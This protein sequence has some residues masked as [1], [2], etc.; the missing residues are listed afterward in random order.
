MFVIDRFQ[1]VMGFLSTFTSFK[2]TK[3]AGRLTFTSINP[4]CSVLKPP[5]LFNSS[6]I[7]AVMW[8]FKAIKHKTMDYLYWMHIMGYWDQ[9][10]PVDSMRL[11]VF[12]VSPN[13]KI[14]YIWYIY[15]IVS[16]TFKNLPNN[17]GASWFQRFLRLL[18]LYVRR[19]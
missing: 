4:R 1:H 8:I 7:S 15:P 3:N 18:V 16:K 9:P 2:W 14:L 12:T 11:A 19:I 5:M 13:C 6:F 10:S 17:I